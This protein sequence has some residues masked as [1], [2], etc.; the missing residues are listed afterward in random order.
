MNTLEKQKFILQS[1]IDSY[2]PLRRYKMGKAKVS[3]PFVFSVEEY[4][5][6]AKFLIYGTPVCVKHRF[7]TDG[8]YR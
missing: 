8:A 7:H 1:I 5:N 3:N 2:P 4:N 6:R